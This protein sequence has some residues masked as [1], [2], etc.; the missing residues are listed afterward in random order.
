MNTILWLTIIVLSGA[1]IITLFKL[2]DEMTFNRKMRPRQDMPA[3]W[4]FTD[5]KSKE[6][7]AAPLAP[8]NK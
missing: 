3:R 8:T 5:A 2:L 7:G 1:I 6:Q 4:Q